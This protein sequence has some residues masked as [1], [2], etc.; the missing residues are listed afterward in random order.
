MDTNGNNVKLPFLQGVMFFF[1][2]PSILIIVN[3]LKVLHY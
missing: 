1:P 2:D 3:E